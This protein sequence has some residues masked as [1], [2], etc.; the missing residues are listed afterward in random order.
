MA[1]SKALLAVEQSLASLDEPDWKA[2]VAAVR[3]DDATF[4]AFVARL[5]PPE[6]T[7][8]ANWTPRKG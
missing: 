2:F 5:R 3:G 1:T 6:P 7:Y 8:P 4:A